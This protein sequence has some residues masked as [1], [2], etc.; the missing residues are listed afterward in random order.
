MLEIGNGG[1]TAEEYR[2]HISLWSMLSAPLLAGN[3]LR[4]MS[5]EI[6]GILINRKVIAIDQD[7]LG[8]QATRAAKSGEIE[9]WKRK[10][11]NGETAIA[12]FNR[13]SDKSEYKVRWT[14]LGMARPSKARALWFHQDIPNIPDAYLVVILGHGAVMLRIRAN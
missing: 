12:I 9:V 3:D 5:P 7:P 13:G 14:D 1:M 2:T 4:S 6:L 11:A 10:L 8:K